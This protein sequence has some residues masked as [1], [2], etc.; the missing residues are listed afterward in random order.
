M[1]DPL[2]QP[3]P[4]T[5]R[6]TPV[7]PRADTYQTDGRGDTALVATAGGMWASTGVVVAIVFVVLAVI[8]AVVF[9]NR[10]ISGQGTGPATPA[11][12]VERSA[13]PAPAATPTVVEPAAPSQTQAAPETPAVP[14]NPAAPANP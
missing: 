8:A 6:P 13:A 9:T 7:A 11:A 1:A 5:Q 12:A 14:A 2:I 3:R 10:D 4:G